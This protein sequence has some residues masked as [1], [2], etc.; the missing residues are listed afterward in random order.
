MIMWNDEL[1]LM[2]FVGHTLIKSHAMQGVVQ[3]EKS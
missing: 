2:M 1:S 3:A